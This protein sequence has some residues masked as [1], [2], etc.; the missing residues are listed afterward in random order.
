[1][2]RRSRK[3][4]AKKSAA[5]KTKVRRVPAARKRTRKKKTPTAKAQAVVHDHEHHI[6][7]CDVDFTAS[8]PTP[9]SALPP[10]RGGVETV[11]AARRK[12]KA[13]KRR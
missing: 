13:S 1:M 8:E 2:A 7:G 12:T 3:R 11:S 6:D 9:D 4:T 5:R 10:A